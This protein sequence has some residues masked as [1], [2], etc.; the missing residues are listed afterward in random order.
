MPGGRVGAVTGGAVVGGA[1]AGGGSETIEGTNESYIGS[2]GLPEDFI[3]ELEQEFGFDKPP[4]ERFL[5]MMWNYMRFDFGE[6]YFRSIS[7]VDLVIEK[8]PVSI[9]LGLW[10]TIIAYIVSIPLGIRKAVRDGSGFDTWTSALIIVAYAIPGFLF[11]ILLLVLSISAFKLVHISV[12][13]LAGAV[14]LV[15]TRTI[16]PDDVRR[17]IDW[18]VLILIGGMPALGK[19]FEKHELDDLV[20]NW[21]KCMSGGMDDPSEQAYA[22]FLLVPWPGAHLLEFRA[23]TT[24]VAVAAVDRVADGLSAV[25]TFFEPLLGGRG[26]GVYAILA[27]I[28]RARRSGLSHLYLGYWIE[29]CGKMR[30]KGAFRPL[31]VL[32]GRCWVEVR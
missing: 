16:R 28:E 1:I 6:S 24:L 27:E 12:A 10:S 22:D 21:M 25:Y 3:K 14:S 26:L 23:A 8:M 31:E 19:A 13:A 9:T 11:A 30:Y 4:L 32:V 17:S 2:R 18:S 29:Q 20:A 15:L 5:N 7:V